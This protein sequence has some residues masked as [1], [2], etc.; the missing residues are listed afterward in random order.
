[1]GL[2]AQE[3]FK[4]VPLYYQFDIDGNY[5]DVY[6]I[7][8]ELV[9]KDSLIDHTVL[10]ALEYIIRYKNKNGVEDLKKA[11]TCLRKAIYLLEN[12]V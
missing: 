6:D 1:M 7:E 3:V 8:L 4:S 12:D 10:D 11:V 9:G 5:F 2:V